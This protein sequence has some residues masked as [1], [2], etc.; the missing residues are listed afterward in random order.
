[1]WKWQNQNVLGGTVLAPARTP[2]RACSLLT[3]T[4]AKSQLLYMQGIVLRRD[5]QRVVTK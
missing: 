1:M 5:L 3:N 4:Y 2:C